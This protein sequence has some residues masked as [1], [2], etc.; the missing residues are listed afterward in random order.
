MR[1]PKSPLEGVVRRGETGCVYNRYYEP[2][3]ERFVV[4]DFN[5]RSFSPFRRTKRERGL[6]S[7]F[8]YL[9]VRYKLLNCMAR[10]GVKFRYR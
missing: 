9:A 3:G 10:S 1:T 6:K 5:R 7:A 8:T 2:D 4:A